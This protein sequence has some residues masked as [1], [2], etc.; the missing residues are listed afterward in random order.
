VSWKSV[1]IVLTICNQVRR[2]LAGLCV[3]ALGESVQAAQGRAYQGVHQIHWQDAYFR[4]DIG[5]RARDL[6]RSGPAKW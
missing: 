6:T 4:T 3:T 2:T 1:Q 5:H